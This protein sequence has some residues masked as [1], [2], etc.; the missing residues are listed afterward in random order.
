MP[1]GCVMN[2]RRCINCGRMFY[3]YNHIINQKYCSRKE[4]QLVRKNTWLRYKLKY[5]QDYRDNKKAA[6]YK[7]KMK[8]RNYSYK[9]NTASSRK[10]PIL[11]ILMGRKAIVDLYKTKTINCDC[12]LVLTSQKNLLKRLRS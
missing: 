3:P 6:Q 7:W 1:R 11:K 5:D 10:K 4:C 12:C 9:K 8:N 2:K